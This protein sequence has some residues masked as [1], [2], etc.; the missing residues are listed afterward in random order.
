[1]TP[2]RIAKMTRKER[3][4]WMKMLNDQLKAENDAIQ[5]SMPSSTG[6]RKTSFASKARR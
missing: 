1:M 2:D 3:I 6:K 5:N 4:Y